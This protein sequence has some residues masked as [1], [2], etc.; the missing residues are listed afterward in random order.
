MQS[1]TKN[2]FFFT[3]KHRQALY[4]V[5]HPPALREEGRRVVS[6]SAAKTK[7]DSDAMASVSTPTKNSYE[8]AQSA[9][10]VEEWRM[11]PPFPSA[12]PATPYVP[13]K[14]VSGSSNSEPVDGLS[15]IGEDGMD[16]SLVTVEVEE[17][18]KYEPFPSAY[19]PT[20]QVVARTVSGSKRNIRQSAMEPVEEQN[21]DFEPAEELSRSY[22]EAKEEPAQRRETRSRS[23]RPKPT[24]TQSLPSRTGRRTR[25]K[26]IPHANSLGKDPAGQDFYRRPSGRV[27]PV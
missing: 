9:S 20:P 15:P 21:Q 6:D 23:A 25:T 8:T 3:N 16:I 14:S 22:K 24:T 13:I 1:V 17:W 4:E 19:P 11:Y 5:W 2:D 18:R 12:Y 7:P 26:D 10:E 27:S